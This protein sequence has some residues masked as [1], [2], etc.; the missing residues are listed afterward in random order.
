[1]K[2][3]NTYSRRFVARKVLFSGN[4]GTQRERTLTIVVLGTPG[5]PTVAVDA[6]VVRKY[7]KGNPTPTPAPTPTPTGVA[8]APKPTPI[9]TPVAAG[10]VVNVTSIPAL[11]S[12]LADNTVDQIIVANGKYHI[13]SAGATVSD[14]L[15]IGGNAYANRTR[16]VLVRAETIGGVTFDGGGGTSFDGAM[17]FED[18]AHD[19]T[20]DGFNF[21]NFSLRQSGA[22]VFGGYISRRTPHH[23]T[24]RHIKILGTVRGTATAATGNTLEHALYFAQAA[25]TGP[26]DIL[27]E[28]ISVDGSGYLASAVHADHGDATNPPA[29]NVTVRRLHVYKT[30]Q[31]IILWSAG[32]RNWTFDTADITNALEYAVRYESAGGSGIKF[33]NVTS[34]GSGVKGF[35]SSLGLSPPGVTLIN[36]SFR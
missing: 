10:K 24:I 6:L 8:P 2:T 15:W 35:Y 33:A 12:A 16:P 29:Y 3:V 19:Q 9:P 32:L 34:T 36:N 1:V 27:A 17:A 25:G 5:H 18:G 21:A 23:L 13:S 30:Q 20:W 7:K 26:H 31:A 22:I 14:S 28:D 4:Y 11:K